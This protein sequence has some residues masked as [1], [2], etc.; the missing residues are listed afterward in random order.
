MYQITGVTTD[1]LQKQTLTLPSGKQIVLT[2]YFM[3]QQYCW[4]IRELNYDSGAFVLDG[5]RITTSLNMLNQFRNKI[6]FGLACVSVG[7]RDPQLQEDFSSGNCK[8]YVLTEDEVASYTEYLGN[9]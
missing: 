4:M 9:G 2:I 5:L 1:P 3:P 8:L 7:N 6:P